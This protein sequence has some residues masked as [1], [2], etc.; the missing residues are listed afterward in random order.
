MGN[1]IENTF[2]CSPN[3]FG[4]SLQLSYPGPSLVH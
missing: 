2:T 4:G 3:T 1:Q